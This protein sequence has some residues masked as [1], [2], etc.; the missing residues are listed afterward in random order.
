[1]GVMGGKVAGDG[2]R[3][4]GRWTKQSVCRETRESGRNLRRVESKLSRYHFVLYSPPFK[5]KFYDVLQ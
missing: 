3:G 1:M 4:G 5:C 2:W